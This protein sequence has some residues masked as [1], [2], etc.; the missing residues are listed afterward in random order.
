MFNAAQDIRVKII[1]SL[2]VSSGLRYGA[3]NILN[4]GDL[5]KIEKY[6]VYKITAYRKSKKFKY[7]TFC[8]PESTTLID[9]YLEYRKNKGEILKGNSP[10]IREQFN[11]NDKLKVNNPRHL[12]LV[13]FRSLINDVLTKY[14]NLRKK[15]SFDYENKRKEG[16]NPTK[17]T[18]GFRKFFNTEC[19]K[20]GVYPDFIEIM[21]GHKLPGVRSHYMKPDIDTL[22]EGTKE[23]KGYLAAIN[24]LTINDENR[25]QK[26][27]EELKQQDDYNKYIIDKK[28]NEKDEQIKGMEK[29]I[30]TIMNTLGEL[31]INQNDTATKN[32]L[33]KDLIDNEIYLP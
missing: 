12:T 5:E 23:V 22:L 8:T 32:K 11:T 20:A 28:M 10:L 2:M 3:V 21:L 16:R 14:T 24:D 7:N 19:A 15:L 13:T 18:H 17:L 6:N 1:I 26:K 30:Q 4:I 25:L 33:A 27:V 31:M 29:Q 9:S